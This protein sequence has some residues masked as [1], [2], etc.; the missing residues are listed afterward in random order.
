MPLD[1]NELK[2]IFN[3]LDEDS[4][5]TLTLNEFRDW[6]YNQTAK[7]TFKKMIKKLREKFVDV[8]GNY[9]SSQQMPF[10]FSIMLEYL[11]NKMTRDA[12]FK[13]IESKVRD[14]KLYCSDPAKDYLTLFK[15]S[16]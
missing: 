10:E 3:H 13:R 16:A 9:I 1:Y 8:N 15:H 2:I 5:G 6:Q 4:T 11:T 7:E 12:I 14:N